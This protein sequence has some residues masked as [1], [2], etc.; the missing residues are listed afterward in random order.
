MVVFIV[1]P[2]SANGSTGR[3]WPAIAERAAAAGLRGEP[4]LTTR[5]GEAA[6]LAKRAVAEGAR[7]VV[8]V[9]GDGTV[10]EVVNGLL[11]SEA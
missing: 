9:G 1:N 8:A 6:A 11:G 7:V 4:L 2:A 5:P 3:R 10:H